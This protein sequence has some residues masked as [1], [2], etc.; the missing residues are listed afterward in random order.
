MAWNDS[1]IEAIEHKRGNVEKEE[2]V[3][4]IGIRE[5]DKREK[6]IGMD[7]EEKAKKV[8]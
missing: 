2:W 5:K 8:L 4:R 3:L 6:A 7:E 1:D